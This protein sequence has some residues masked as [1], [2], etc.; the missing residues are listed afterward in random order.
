MF[1]NVQRL[2]YVLLFFSLMSWA[3]VEAQVKIQ[4]RKVLELEEKIFGEL[5]QDR[6]K[7]KI[8]RRARRAWRRKYHKTWGGYEYRKGKITKRHTNPNAVILIVILV[9]AAIVTGL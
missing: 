2:V 7:R 3:E 4:E 9:C 8:Q 5:D 1:G 6:V